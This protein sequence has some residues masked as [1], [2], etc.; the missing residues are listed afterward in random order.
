MLKNLNEILV[1]KTYICDWYRIIIDKKKKCDSLVRS[2]LNDIS[3]NMGTNH[4]TNC[5]RS[6]CSS[7]YI[8]IEYD[9]KMSKFT[10]RRVEWERCVKM[11]GQSLSY[12]IRAQVILLV[13][14]NERTLSF[15][16]Y[17]WVIAHHCMYMNVSKASIFL[18]SP[19]NY[20]LPTFLSLNIYTKAL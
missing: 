9:T 18:F 5:C 8:C 14:F 12:S 17:W 20:R 11:I 15:S 4:I 16:Y 19:W 3:S 2:E 10:Y 13:K 1:E 6:Y 7:M